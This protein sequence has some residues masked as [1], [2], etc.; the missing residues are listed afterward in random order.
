MSESSIYR[1]ENEAGWLV[2][3]V[4]ARPPKKNDKWGNETA[5][6]F[7]HSL[8]NNKDGKMKTVPVGDNERQLSDGEK[9]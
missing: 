2:G 4:N 9:K 7:W 6:A 3:Q 5:N 8:R 1:P